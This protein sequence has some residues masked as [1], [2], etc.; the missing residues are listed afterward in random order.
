MMDWTKI[1]K[2]SPAQKNSTNSEEPTTVVPA[3]MRSPKM[4]G[5]HCK[6][7]GFTWNIKHE[8]SSPKFYEL[9]IKTGIKRDTALD[10]KNFYNKIKMCLNLVTRLQEEPLPDYQSIK[11]HFDFE[12]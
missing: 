9:L 12:K 1:S 8:I 7:K 2:Y 6:K 3:N 10:L 11:R 4:E 5:G